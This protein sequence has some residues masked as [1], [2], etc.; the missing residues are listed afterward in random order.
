MY[1]QDESQQRTELRLAFLRHLPKRIEAVCRRARRFCEEGWDINGLSLLHEDVQ[2]LAGASGRY[3][4]LEASEQLLM[5]ETLLGELAESGGL[6]DEHGSGHLIALLDDLL[7]QLDASALDAEAA[8]QP[9]PIAEPASHVAA[10]ARA[11]AETPPPGYW[12]RWTGDAPPASETLALAE[13]TVSPK[14]SDP[15]SV[16]RPKAPAPAVA[17]ARPPESAPSNARATSSR[18]GNGTGA[19]RRIYHLTDGDAL[20]C[21]LDQRLESQGYELELLES[22]AELKEI[23]NALAPDLVIVDAAFMND[24]EGVGAVLRATRER[25][26][27]RLPMLVISNEDS[28]PA[29]LVARRAGAD[30][31]LVRPEG[32]E[33]VMAK[34]AELLVSAGEATYR[35]LVVED[36]RSQ[37]L[38]AESILRNAGMEVRSVHEAFDVL[39]SMEDFRPDLVLMDLYM[40]HCDGTELTALIREREEFLHTPIVFLSGESDQDKHFEALSAGGDD[41]L[42]KP[43]RP[44][45]LIAA[46]NNRV[47]RA[48]AVQERAQL[49]DPR[50]PSTG[51]HRR[52]YMLDRLAETLAMD[53]VRDHPGGLLFLEIE[54]VPQLREQYGLSTLEQL[55]SEVG[56]QV[57]D[58]LAEGELA[59]RYS[60]GC[61]VVYSAE[62]D[63]A[64]LERLA[65]DLR[66]GLITHPFKAEGKPLRLR[67]V[68]GLASF[69]H[70]FADAGAM[71]NA[72]E[73]AAR[74]AR[75]GDRGVHR[76]APPQRRAEAQTSALLSLIRNAI[77]TDGFELLYQPIVALQGGDDAQYQSLLRLRDDHGRLH[78][79]AAIVPLAESADLILEVDR[80]VLT[81]AIR[82]IDQRRSGARPVRLFVSQS[83]G[84]LLAPGQS[85]WIRAQLAARQVPG[86]SLVLELPLEDVEARADAVEAFCR[87]LMPLGVQF[88]LSRFDGE[89]SAEA[90]LKRLPLSFVK[91]APKYLAA[92]QTPALRDELRGLVDLGHRAGLQ[93]IGQRVE[94]AQAAATLW[95]SGIDYI[96]GNLVQQ[97][98]RELEFDFQA[99][100]L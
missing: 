40:P 37:A 91:I 62:R 72:A 21:E 96:Q 61:Y 23:L 14:S 38:F 50:D 49:R 80:W 28:I 41:F 87:E 58:S 6:P 2:R 67:A 74:E 57:S 44:K 76:F 39:Q 48:R 81:Q 64:S 20:A 3:G 19:G 99:A 97:A 65:V 29:R 30:A 94:D 98:A 25:T 85:E 32:A 71:L 9:P 43:I 33:T 35:V 24:I 68:A 45:H 83:T 70:N 60:D 52:S 46:V 92:A 27:T 7:P 31:L 17:P 75:G 53:N 11:H 100:V 8:L 36:D 90:L 16:L 82:M 5:L 18:A 78:P 89:H 1:A 63:E 26:G 13:T 55:M 12:R 59:C 77:D 51:L 79:A 15:E 42:S 84:S 4:A 66:N 86:E 73:R 22:P 10:S 93:V 88:C 34:L 95:M 69:R 54:G 56:S 47:R